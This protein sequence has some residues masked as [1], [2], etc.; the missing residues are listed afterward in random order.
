MEDV[1]GK[2]LENA[3]TVPVDE[4]AEKALENLA[5]QGKH[6]TPAERIEQKR[7]NLYGTPNPD[8]ETKERIDAYMKRH[9]NV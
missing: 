9:Y 1:L 2:F 6:M 3:R 7:Y 5:K 8:A 4:K